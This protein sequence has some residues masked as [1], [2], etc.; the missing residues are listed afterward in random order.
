MSTHSLFRRFCVLS[1]LAALIP[2]APSDAWAGVF[3][4][5]HFV[6]P[7]EYSLGVEPEVTLTSGAGLAANLRYTH[8]V[9]DFGNAT[10]IIGSGG[11]PRRFRLGGNLTFDL[12]PDIEGQPGI[13]VAGQALY[14]RLPHAGK[15][16]F[17]A[18]PYIH[19]TFVFQ[20]SEVEPFFAF[21][22]GASLSESN[23]EAISAVAVGA[24]FK[25]SENF[26]FVIELGIAVNHTESYVSG[27]F[28]YYP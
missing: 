21:P 1:T 26:R 19:K 22:F 2:S 25:N 16:E 3:S 10:A 12:F 6:A 20:S 9:S 14:V 13:G 18:I 15:M 11:G 8:G 27:G 28:V 23:Y 24:L 7:G 4:T 5:P 17:T